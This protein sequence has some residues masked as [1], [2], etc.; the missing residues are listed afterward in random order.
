MAM[1]QETPLDEAADADLPPEL[2]SAGAELVGGAVGAAIGGAIAGPL[3]IVL[4]A[5]GAPLAKL[6]ADYLQRHVSPRQKVRVGALLL[7]ARRKAYENVMRG[8]PLREDGFLTPKGESRPASE[9]IAEAAVMAAEREVQEKKILYM[10]NLVGNLPFR[11]EI[12]PI[13]ASRMLKVAQALSYTQLTLLAAVANAEIAL[14]PQGAS[15][16]EHSWRANSVAAEFAELGYAAME[17]TFAKQP[18]QEDGGR[19]LPTNLGVPSDQ[20]LRP[21]AA[22]MVELLGLAAIPEAEQVDAAAALYERAGLAPPPP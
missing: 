18:E 16:V 10:G 5:A 7:F 2:A 14:P 8:M 22:A 21:F 13:T 6:G 4:G 17:L 9:E 15:T 1:V 11:P 3:G 20:A 19:R 12:D